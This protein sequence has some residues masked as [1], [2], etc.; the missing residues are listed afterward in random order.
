MT[1]VGIARV[2]GFSGVRHIEIPE[3]GITRDIKHSRY[4]EL[5]IAIALIY[6]YTSGATHID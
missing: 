3:G 6:G 5:S 2:L 1:R 4:L